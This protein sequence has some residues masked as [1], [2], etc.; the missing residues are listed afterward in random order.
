MTTPQ[1]NG[2]GA[3]PDGWRWVRLEDVAEVNPRRP[4]LTVEADTP[5]TFI[6]MAAI[7]E[8][9]AGIQAR[10][11]RPYNAVNGGYTYFEENDV[12]FAKITP[13]LQ[14]GKHALARGLSGGFGFGTTE[15]HVIRPGV[16]IEPRHLFRV[17]T[18]QASI[19]K[20]VR[21]F[22]GTAGQQRVQPETLRSF[23]IL[24]PPLVEQRAIAAV[25]DSIDEAIERTEEVIAATEALRDSLLHELLTRGVPG[26]HTQWNEVP[27]IGTIP[28]AWHVVRLGDLLE[29]DQ[30]GAWGQEPYDD[31]AV[32][33]LRAT[34]LTKDGRIDPTRIVRRQLSD[35][36]LVK[37]Q[38]V[39]DDILLERS[40][41]GPGAP[42]GRVAL[43]GGLAPIYCSNFCQQL[44]F[45]TSR[46]YQPF[47]FRFLWRLYCLGFTSRLEHRTT[48][49]RNLDYSAYLSLPVYLPTISEQMTIAAWLDAADESVEQVRAVLSKRI[50]VKF[51]VAD[52]LLTGHGRVIDP[53]EVLG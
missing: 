13:C 14:N 52:T 45:D 41:G 47:M 49:I 23:S 53:E 20:C 15:V 32:P 3:V 38:M 24:L 51:S 44:R 46:T 12:L 40:G 36:D 16:A 34:N 25:L 6:P 39:S 5:V 2:N 21:N 22:T 48:G 42:V 29:L 1:T 26:W 8:N 17:I 18:Q 28:A 27:G 33:V 37:R 10:E 11:Q 43:I 50:D 9:L 30:P 7:G 31:G 4:S 19:D 35:R